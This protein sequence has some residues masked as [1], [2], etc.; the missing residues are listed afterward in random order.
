MKKIAI[1]YVL[2]ICCWS[3]NAYAYIDPSSSLY[4]IQGLFAIVG[5]IIFYIRH[6]I[7][8]I[9]N[10]WKKIKGNKDA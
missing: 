2:S 5:A 8:A 6:P 7:E 9:K 1:L 3:H 4:L 10:L